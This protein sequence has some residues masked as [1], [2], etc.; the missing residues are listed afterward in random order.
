[1]AYRI[2]NGVWGLLFTYAVVVQFNDPDPLRWVLIYGAAACLCFL[3]VA[4][5]LP[6]RP[7]LGYAAVAVVLGVDTWFR[8]RGDTDP[9]AGFPSWGIFNQEVVREVGGLVLVAIWMTVL[10]VWTRLR[11]AT[12]S[13]P[14]PD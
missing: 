4:G 9:M 13:A 3:A 8:F 1:M 2:L 10:G 5:R 11:R 14:S 6:W 12:P 7:P